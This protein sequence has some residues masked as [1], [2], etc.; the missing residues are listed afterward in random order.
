MYS[1]TEVFVLQLFKMAAQRGFDNS[2]AWNLCLTGAPVGSGAGG[3]QGHSNRK[4]TSRPSSAAGVRNPNT[5]STYE[6]NRPML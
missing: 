5:V 3:A 1:F 4:T 2:D 6:V